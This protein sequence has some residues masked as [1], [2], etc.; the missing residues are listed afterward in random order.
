[1]W[2]QLAVATAWLGAALWAWLWEFV[3]SLLYERGSHVVTPFI[4]SVSLDQFLHWG[5]PLAFA[6]VGGFLFWK[7]RPTETVAQPSG[8]TGD[9]MIPLHEAAATLYAAIRGTYLAQVTEQKCGSPSEILDGMGNLIRNSATIQVRRPP[10][11][12]WESF[13]AS[14]LPRT[15][16]YDG[17]AGIR[18]HGGAGEAVFTDPRVRKGDLDR[19][20][21]EAK[22]TANNKQ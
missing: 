5:P 17:A 21:S 18:Y 11:P 7:M 22:A 14:E 3:R 12:A 9:A 4:E 20:V 10:S 15:Q 6:A 2:R 1:M 16:V 19:I 8:P 13:P